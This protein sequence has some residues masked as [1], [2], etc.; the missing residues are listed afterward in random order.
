MYMPVYISLMLGRSSGNF[1]L[2][3]WI[4]TNAFIYTKYRQICTSLEAHV[5]QSL[6][7]QTP[8]DNMSR[9]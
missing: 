5:Y 7:V 4:Y 3:A 9:K 1:A 2:Y 6:F 8:T